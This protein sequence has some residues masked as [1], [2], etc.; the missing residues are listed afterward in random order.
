MTMREPVHHYY[1]G[2]AAALNMH[3]RMA[4]VLLTV[5]SLSMDSPGTL[6][7]ACQAT[8]WIAAHAHLTLLGRLERS[9]VRRDWYQCSS[10]FG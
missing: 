2:G 1:G 6:S 8:L 7:P 9:N 3:E 4:D 10:R 5:L